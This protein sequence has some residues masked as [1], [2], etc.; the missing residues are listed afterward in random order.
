M[1][2]SFIIWIRIFL[3]EW[4]LFDSY[5]LHMIVIITHLHL[6]RLTSQENIPR[7][8]FPLYVDKETTEQGA[9]LS[10]SLPLSGSYLCGLL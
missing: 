9:L 8:F 4:I 3:V 6:S 7:A 2:F 10:K 5:K 1:V